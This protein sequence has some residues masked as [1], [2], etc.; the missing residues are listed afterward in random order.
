[1]I[2]LPLPATKLSF[3]T[4]LVVL[5]STLEV[6]LRCLPSNRLL[7]ESLAN[8]VLITGDFAGDF[9]AVKL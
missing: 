7:D 4:L 9:F 5:A 1:M 2:D 6:M 3:Y 8:A